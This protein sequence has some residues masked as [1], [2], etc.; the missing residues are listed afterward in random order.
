VPLGAILPLTLFVL[1]TFVSGQRKL[2]DWSATW[3]VFHLGVF[4]QI[5]YENNFVDA[6]ARHECCSF[7]LRQT[8]RGETEKLRLESQYIRKP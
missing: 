3:R 4:A 7:R 2:G 6:F 5:S 1:K 8:T